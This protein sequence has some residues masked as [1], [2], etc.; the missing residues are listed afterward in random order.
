MTATEQ[1]AV[2]DEIIAA[3]SD[4]LDDVLPKDRRAEVEKKLKDDPDWKRVHAELR[5]T[6]EAMSGLMR[7]PAGRGRSPE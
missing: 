7:S 4:Y 1:T 3:V 2:D 5:E 6:R